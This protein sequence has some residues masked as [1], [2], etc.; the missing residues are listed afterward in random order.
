MKLLVSCKVA[1]ELAVSVFNN[2]APPHCAPASTKLPEPS[3]LIQLPETS[4]PVTVATSVVLP[5]RVPTIGEAPAPP[6]NTGI[7]AVRTPEDATVDVLEKYGTPPDVPE[8]I[9]R[10]PPARFN[11]EAVQVP[12]GPVIVPVSVA[13]AIVGLMDKTTLPRLPVTVA[14][15]TTPL[16]SYKTRPLV[17][18]LIGVLLIV[19]PPE[20]EPH[21]G[22]ALE[23]LKRH[24]PD[25]TVL[26]S[27]ANADPVE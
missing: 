17:P 10:P 14:S 9:P 24:R 22:A 2:T 23:P 26:A 20:H 5:D 7:F 3:D 19:I 8:V 12:A 13:E 27:N 18:L 25:V 6:P 16:L 4:E 21:V 15:P 11:P 1:D